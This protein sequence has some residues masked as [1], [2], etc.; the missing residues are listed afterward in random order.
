MTKKRRTYTEKLE[1][2]KKLDKISEYNKQTIEDFVSYLEADSDVSDKKIYEYIG[3][4]KVIFQE[5]IDFNILKA[6]KKQMQKAVGKIRRTDKSP[7]TQANYLTAI[8]KLYRTIYELEEDRPKDVKR[9]LN[10]SFMKGTPQGR[11]NP[12]N[13][14]TPQEV[15][16]LSEQASNP[17]DRLIPIILF[18]T[19]ARIS[20]ITGSHESAEGLKLKNVELKQKNAVV[21]LETLKRKDQRGEYPT[22]KLPLTRSIDALQKWLSQHPDR[23]NPESHLFVTM[24]AS[25]NGST[26][27]DSFSNRNIKRI[28]DKLKERAEIDKRCNP[29]AFRHASATHKGMKWTAEKLKWWHGWA[30]LETAQNYIQ[31]DEERLIKQH[32]Q[33][34]G[35]EEGETDLEGSYKMKT[36]SRCGEEWSPTMKYCGSCSLALDIDSAIEAEEAQKAKDKAVEEGLKTGREELLERVKQLEEKL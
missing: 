8:K 5:Y 29:H 3:T 7:H 10:A 30:K 9:I 31:E 11:K 27:G 12:Y 19:G 33:E 34:E 18:E 16:E 2:F 28:L 13:A 26:P 21:E 6:E 25:K 36:C 23:D 20:E 32:L 22:R 1:E 24:Q 15:M 35:I 17:R 4:F 14:L